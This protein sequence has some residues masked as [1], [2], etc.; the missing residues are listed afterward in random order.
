LS[1]TL[2]L[3]VLRVLECKPGT[4]TVQ[5]SV[6]GAPMRFAILTS[7]NLANW[8]A[9]VTNTVPFSF[10]D[11]NAAWPGCRFYQ[12]LPLPWSP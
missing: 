11:T 9:L 5:V 10:V 1:V 6:S 3:G 4:V 2:P 7:T 8:T 12:A